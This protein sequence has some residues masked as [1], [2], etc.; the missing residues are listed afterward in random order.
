MIFFKRNL[1]MAYSKI[2]VPATF[3]C[4]KRIYDFIKKEKGNKSISAF[5]YELLLNGLNLY[6]ENKEDLLNGTD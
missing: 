1:K 4:E 6:I 3:K 5:I 2:Y